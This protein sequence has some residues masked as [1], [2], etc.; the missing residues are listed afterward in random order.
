MGIVPARLV[1]ADDGVT[2]YSD[3]YGDLYHAAAGGLEQARHVFIGGNDLPQRWQARERFTILEIGFGQGLNFLATWAAWH[4]DPQ[5]C[6]RLH[7]LAVEKHPFSTA[8]LTRLHERYPELCTLAKQLQGQWPELTPGFHRL[9]FAGGR[10]VLT[11]AFAEAIAAV[12]LFV[13]EPDAIYLDGFS[14]AK[15]PELWSP[16]LLR[17]IGLAAAPGATAATWSVAA[18]VRDALGA[19]GFSVE[20]RRGFLHKREMTVARLPGSSIPAAAG[21]RRIAVVGAGLAG[22]MVAER[23]ATRGWQVELFER[24]AAPARETSGNLTAAMLPVMSLD[25]ARLSRLNRSAYLHA[26]R[27]MQQQ[28]D[29]GL[30]IDGAVCGVLQLAR[31]AEHADKQHAILV[32]NGFPESFVRY[33]EAAAGSELAGLPVAGPGWWFGGGAWAHPASLCVAALARHPGAID[34]L[35]STTVADLRA[36]GNGWRLLGPSGELLTETEH[37]VL[38][39]ALDI[40]RLT[41]SAHLPLFRFR[42]QVS[43]LPAGPLASLRCVVCREGYLTPAYAGCNSVGASF[44]RGGEAALRDMDHRANLARLESMLPGTMAAFDATSL[45]G[46]VGF[47][48]VSPD[49]SP[50]LGALYPATARPQGRDLAAV[51]RLPGLWVASGY[52]ARGLV[53]APLMAE[54]LASQ[55]AG[56]PLPLPADLVGAVD[57]ARFARRNVD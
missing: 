37:V 4:D 34:S 45:G 25:D 10:V 2:P 30:V 15:N 33:V 19:A 56:D 7:Y 55:I 20:R 29:A 26:L 50:L 27:W 11:L 24:Q 22:C 6:A 39:G 28:R 17:E 49:K 14:P 1:F 35:F 44:H 47:R 32:R 5:R 8:D 23:F 51:E 48:P 46:R 16:Q 54:L 42:G 40:A 43:H 21:E 36:S 13:G 52:G 38:A 53:W 57:P 12:P 31:D 3:T 9:E 18:P 41:P